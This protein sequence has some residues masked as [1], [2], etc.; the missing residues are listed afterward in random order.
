MC[1]PTAATGAASS[2]TAPKRVA[3]IGGGVTGL[4][5]AWHLHT[6][7]K[8]GQ[9][10][11]EVEVHVFEAADRLGGHAHTLRLNTENFSCRDLAEGE[12]TANKAKNNNEVDIDCGFM[13]YN[14]SNYPNMTEWFSALSVEP[15]P[16]DMSLSISLD[17]GNTVEWSSTSLSGLL[18]NPAQ[19]LDS[20]FYSF[21]KDMIHFHS[22]AGNLLL[23][24]ENDPKR[25]VTMGEYLRNE[26][27]G[28]GLASYYLVPMMAALWSAS[29]EDVMKFPAVSLVEFMCN[30]RMLQLFDRPLWNTPAGR[31]IQYVH[32]M[33]TL[34]AK[35]AHTSTPI[36]A[37]NK[38]PK[39]PSIV[40][41][42]GDNSFVYELFTTDNTSMG[43]FDHVVFACHPPVAND[44]LSKCNIINSSE[45]IDAKLLANLRKIQYGDNV[46]YIHSDPKLMPKRK[47]A[48]ASW[49]C[50]GKSRYLTTHLRQVSGNDSAEKNEKAIKREAMEGAAS[51][52]GARLDNQD[53]EKEVMED[54]NG[55]GVVTDDTQKLEGEHGRMRAVYVTYHINRLQNLTTSRDI[56]VSLNPHQRPDSELVYRRQ[57]MSH[58]QFTRETLAGR[59]AI[60]EEF[61]GK[62]GLW[63]CGA[64][65]GYGFHEDGCRSGFEVATAINGVPLPWAAQK[66]E[67]DD[68]AV[69]VLPPPDLAQFT[70][71]QNNGFFR[72]LKHF[73][74]YRIPVAICKA[75]VTSFLKGAITKG[76]LRLRLNDGTTLS[77]GDKSEVGGDDQPVTAR[78][79]DDWFFVKVATE[80]D[81]GLARSYMAGQFVVEPLEKREK[82]HWSLCPAGSRDET[83]DVI[84]DPIGLTR[85]FLLFVGNRDLAS[86]GARRSAKQH[87]YANALQN[88][89]GLAISKMGSFLNYLRFKITM[90]NSERGG[91]LKNIHA[92]YDISNDL[93]R[94]FLDKETLMYSSAIYD[95]V[96]APPALTNG[97]PQPSAGLVF[98][99]SLEEAQWRKLD[100]LLDRAQ[101]QPGQSMLDIGF[102][103]GGLS[104]HAARKYGCRVHGITLSVEQKALAETRVEKEGLGHLITF[105]VIDYRTFARKKENQGRFDR[106][107]SC[108][109]IEAVGHEHL[110]EF[111][112]AVEQV[113]KYDGVLVMEAITT[114]EARYETY[115][116]TTDFINTIIFPG[117]LCPSLHALVDA[118]YKWST[119]TLEH[120]DNIGLHYAETLAEWRRRFNAKESVVRK[121]GFDDVF[122][123][124]WNYYLTYCE[125][126]FRSQTENCLILVFSRPGNRALVPLTETRSVT[127]LKSLTKEEVNAW[128]EG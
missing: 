10:Y 109:M 47:S 97:V 66:K 14:P 62:N 13:V 51:G 125:A 100:T 108:E 120:I 88:A 1:K 15:E 110:G 24:P 50:M 18:A 70:H 65:M 8:Q 6:Q 101:I 99:G 124:V 73:L 44:I 80:Y 45:T 54:D 113:L 95:A 59:K 16:S 115:L 2:H 55:G 61:Q 69:M 33:A 116:R 85:L 19:L 91:S 114:P 17:G 75:F 121:L 106:V 21:F 46:V 36:L 35:N 87:T 92:H 89:S 28:E 103:W 90:D 86:I 31:S 78:I 7:S 111:F 27:Y 37:M 76:E 32:K 43:T 58:P 68:A 119:L 94:T 60:K 56:F 122:M 79:F 22:H 71:Q 40:D 57:I 11:N 72:R 127:Q 42:A 53:E 20:K 25:Q 23:L 93:F 104:L 82:Y 29:V 34:L 30:H 118:S 102:G 105:E 41:S 83:N 12:D 98:K 77:F 107:I 52:F 39:G 49:N 38:K 81:L 63:F 64:W 96:A 117:S 3:V 5:A 126:G 4:A 112:W 128:L 84:G 74:S 67:K 123:R 48:W 9:G 26:G